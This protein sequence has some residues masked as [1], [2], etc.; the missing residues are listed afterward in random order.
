MKG[1][2]V[3][4]VFVHTTARLPRNEAEFLAVPEELDG[5]GVPVYLVGDQQ[6]LRTRVGIRIRRAVNVLVRFVLPLFGRGNSNTA[7]NRD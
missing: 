6:G 7:R 1:T 4:A 3:G 5:H 2:E